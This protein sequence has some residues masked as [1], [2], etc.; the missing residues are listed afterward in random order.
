MTLVRA[1]I[2]VRCAVTVLSL[3]INLTF[4]IEMENALFSNAGAHE[5]S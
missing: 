1:G 3:L 5:T 2:S 4:G